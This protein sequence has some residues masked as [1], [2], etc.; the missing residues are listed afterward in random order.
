MLDT[1]IG[2][3]Q[4]E[5]EG[6]ALRLWTKAWKEFNDVSEAPVTPDMRP[7]E[8]TKL[9]VPTTKDVSNNWRKSLVQMQKTCDNP[10]LIHDL[11]A[12][13]H[14]IQRYNGTPWMA[15]AGSESGLTGAEGTTT[16]GMDALHR[17][18]EAFYSYMCPTEYEKRS[19]LEVLKRI[20]KAIETLWRDQVVVE[21]FG[22]YKTDTYLPTSDIDLVVIG[23]WNCQ[24]LIELEQYFLMNRY[25]YPQDIQVL[26]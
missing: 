12:N 24:P 20:T 2:W 16:D 3:F 13:P 7:T 18:I 15:R 9:L 23:R 19:R 17:E 4:R 11:N 6:P 21:C 25:C 8:D 26:D 1:S 10:S 14:L 22:S 5:Q